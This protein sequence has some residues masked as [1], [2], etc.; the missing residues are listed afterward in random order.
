MNQ[1]EFKQIQFSDQTGSL[2]GFSS[3]LR[4]NHNE[5]KTR[6]WVRSRCQLDGKKFE[7]CPVW[8]ANSVDSVFKLKRSSYPHDLAGQ[9]RRTL[10]RR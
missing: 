6:P 9:G 7:T 2:H 5:N 3:A 4:I 10:L 1:R 8:G